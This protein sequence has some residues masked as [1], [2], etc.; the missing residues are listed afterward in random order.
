[1]SLGFGGAR[2]DG[3]PADQVL[4]VLRGDRVE[5]FGGGWQAF[6]GQVQQQLATDV[7]AILDLERVVQVR[8]VDQAFP[9]DGGAWLLEIHAHDQIQGIG[10]FRRENLQALGVLVG[11]LDVVDRAGP[12]DHEQAMVGAIQNIANDF[13]A[14]GDG[15]Q[16]GI[17]QGD[18]TLE[19]VGSDQRLVG[20]DV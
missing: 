4:Q 7:Q 18:I 13:A 15:A 9:A 20:S 1:M 16:G 17:A 11:R 12:D 19:L 6:F 14:L 2:A 3:R 5:G 8:V 10:H